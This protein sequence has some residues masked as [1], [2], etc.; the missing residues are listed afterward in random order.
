MGELHNIYID[1]ACNYIVRA[2]NTPG[3]LMDGRHTTL[4]RMLI[5]MASI[6]ALVA[7]MGAA[8]ADDYYVATWGDNNAQGDLTHPWQNVSYA[9]QQAVAG[10]TIHLFDGTWYCEQVSFANSGNATHSVNMVAYNGTPILDASALT[11]EISFGNNDYIL[12]DGL[13]TINYAWIH[14]GSHI[15]ISNCEID[16]GENRSFVISDPDSHYNTIEN[17]TLYDSGWNTIQ[18]MANREPPNGNGIPTTHITVRNCTIYNSTAHNA[19]DL[20]G[21]FQNVTIEDNE[22]YANPAGC[23]Y[24]HDAP[25]HREYVTIRDNYFHDTQSSAINIGANSYYEIYN[26]TFENIPSHNVMYLY[27][28]A[29]DYEIY[30]NSFYNCLSPRTIGGYNFVFDRNYIHTDSGVPTFSYGSNGTVRNPLGKKQLIVKFY[31]A[32]ADMEFD[33]GTVFTATFGGASEYTSVRY[34]P[35]KSNCSI[36]ALDGGQHTLTPTTYDVTLRPTDAYLKDVSVNHVSDVAD[37]RTN[38]SM[39]SS[40]SSNPTWINA[41]MQNFSHTYKVYVDGG[42]V[43]QVVSDANKIK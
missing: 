28:N 20:Y 14:P 4:K 13:K 32:T 36:T 17:C 22:L 23:I 42:Y 21:N 31:N 12:V 39:D 25:D 38:V 34:Y 24:E 40:V 19:I 11:K 15:H 18:L 2:L 43:T 9:T 33:D 8:S 1:S 37:D 16:L 41:T 29:H 30:N 3:E 6:F 5:T 26:N 35:D 27:C 7:L 10:D